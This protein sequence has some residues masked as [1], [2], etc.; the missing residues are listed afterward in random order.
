[1]TVWQMVGLCVIA[2][3]LCVVL[4]PLHPELAMIL[5]LAA[6][7]ILLLAVVGEVGQVLALAQKMME[8]AHLPG[9]YMPI[10]LKAL[11]ICLLT[12]V[13]C[14]TCR[15]AGETAL[16]V[17]LEMAGKIAVLVLSL[18]L[19]EEILMVIQALIAPAGGY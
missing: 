14:D 6:G 2:A 7:S 19:F 4:R 12:Q 13:A 15:D 5:S 10:L 3:L 11:G 17:K 18:P 8:K 1:M 9:A 16:S